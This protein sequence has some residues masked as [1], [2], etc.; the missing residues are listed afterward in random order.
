MRQH[1]LLLNVTVFVGLIPI[2]NGILSVP[3]K[4]S[5]TVTIGDNVPYFYEI[6]LS[7]N[8][9]SFR[10]MNNP[11]RAQPSKCCMQP[12]HERHVGWHARA[13]T[14]VLIHNFSPRRQIDRSRVRTVVSLPVV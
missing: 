11:P 8:Y 13:V 7:G 9:C 6:P 1:D 10:E 12:H 2:P 4:S 14:V 3:L 5:L